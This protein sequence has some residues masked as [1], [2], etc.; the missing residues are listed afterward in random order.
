MKNK[1]E[2]KIRLNDGSMVVFVPNHA[3]KDL[4]DID[5]LLR[6]LSSIK[7]VFR[8]NTANKSDY[9]NFNLGAKIVSND[10]KYTMIGHINYFDNDLDGD[11]SDEDKNIV[12]KELH[13]LLKQVKFKD[14]H[15]SQKTEREPS[16]R[17]LKKRDA[18][19]YDIN[20]V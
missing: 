18:A 10:T 9:V 16:E 15:T 14:I 4:I 8:S 19:E 12:I 1:P 3:W 17:H 2:F 7:T 13:E 5:L 11:S 6:I 20:K